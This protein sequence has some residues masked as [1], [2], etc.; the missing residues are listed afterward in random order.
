MSNYSKLN[1]VSYIIQ[2]ISVQKR[3]LFTKFGFPTKDPPL[4]IWG[5]FTK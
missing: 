1:N 3:N 5:K 4:R 2:V